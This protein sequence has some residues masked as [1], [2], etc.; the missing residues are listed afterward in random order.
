MAGQRSKEEDVMRMC[1]SEHLKEMLLLN[2]KTKEAMTFCR[3][4]PLHVMVPAFC[5][6]PRPLFRKHASKLHLVLS[7]SSLCFFCCTPSYCRCLCIITM[8][9]KLFDSC[10]I[11]K[12][13]NIFQCTYIGVKCIMSNC[14]VSL[15]ATQLYVCCASCEAPFH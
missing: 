3:K 13:S 2:K 15:N 9:I 12:K 7:S 14:C 4:T 11:I 8:T 6:R 10:Y 1:P 5:V